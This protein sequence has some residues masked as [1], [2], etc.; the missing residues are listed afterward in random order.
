LVLPFEVL[1]VLDAAMAKKM[2]SSK[3][4]PVEQALLNELKELGR[5]KK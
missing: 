2:A 1:D 3:N 5:Y 4:A